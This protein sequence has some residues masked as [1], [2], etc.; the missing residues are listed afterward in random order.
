MGA[1][2][3]LVNV[4]VFI[5]AETSSRSINMLQLLDSLFGS[6]AGGGQGPNYWTQ[7]LV[8]SAEQGTPQAEHTLSP[9]WM[10]F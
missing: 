2:N 5:G 6:P 9:F 10:G 4:L 7:L 8:F 3:I 1:L